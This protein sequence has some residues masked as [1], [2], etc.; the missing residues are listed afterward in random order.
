MNIKQMMKQAQEMQAKLTR[1]MADLRVE[2]SAGGGAVRATMSGSKELVDLV[3]D[4][5]VVAA[6]DVE[7]LRDLILAAVNEAGSKV[8]ETLG[9]KVGGM[10]PGLGI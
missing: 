10:V 1:E 5:S 9:S 8:D 3:I 4:P 7:M 6:G 2:A